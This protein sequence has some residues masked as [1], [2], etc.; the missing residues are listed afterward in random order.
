MRT[1]SDV[2]RRPSAAIRNGSRWLGRARHSAH[3]LRGVGTLFQ[4]RCLSG[5]L[6]PHIEGSEDGLMSTAGWYPETVMPR[7]ASAGAAS[8]APDADARPSRGDRR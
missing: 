5:I 4:C 6:S 1:G 7:H 3:R 2:S 8:W